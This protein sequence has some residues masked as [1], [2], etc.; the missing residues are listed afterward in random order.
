[1][2]A[3]HQQAALFQQ[4]HQIHQIRRKNVEA[5]TDL[6][7]GDAGVVRD[8]IEQR[9]IHDLQAIDRHAFGEHLDDGQRRAPRVVAHQR[10][11]EIG[12]HRVNDVG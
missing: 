11:Q 2:G 10:A 6:A 12:V 4:A 3:A 7:R 8:Q 9:E 5:G 1:M